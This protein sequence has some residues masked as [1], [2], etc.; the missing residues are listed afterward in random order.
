MEEK[1]FNQEIF[2]AEIKL[3]AA[4]VVNT[5]K[6][7]QRPSSMELKQAENVNNF[8]HSFLRGDE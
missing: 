1:E 7:G 4:D 5:L 8:I 2:I 6:R 3:E